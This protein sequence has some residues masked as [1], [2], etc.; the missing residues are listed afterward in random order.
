M[1]VQ[2]QG[3]TRM[4]LFPMRT[5]ALKRMPQRAQ[6]SRNGRRKPRYA[7]ASSGAAPAVVRASECTSLSRGESLALATT[8]GGGGAARFD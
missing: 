5:D 4:P 3:F 6:F 1:G 8:I 2:T 7:G